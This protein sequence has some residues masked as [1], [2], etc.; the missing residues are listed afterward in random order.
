MGGLVAR[1]AMTRMNTMSKFQGLSVAE[2][3]LLF[4]ST[5]HSGSVEAERSQFLLALGE[6]LFGLRKDVVNDLK[7]FNPS[8]VDSID[9]LKNMKVKPVFKC[10]C[11]GEPTR[12]MGKDFRVSALLLSKA[13][14]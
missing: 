11:E 13:R 10:F 5:P 7:L 12:V 14:G 4:L 9:I 6:G 8:S 2:C 1:L 3:G